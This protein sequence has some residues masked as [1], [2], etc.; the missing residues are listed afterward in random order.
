MLVA[1]VLCNA[2][3]VFFCLAASCDL[4]KSPIASECCFLFIAHFSTG[5]ISLSLQTILARVLCTLNGKGAPNNPLTIA[6]WPLKVC[7][8]FWPHVFHLLVVHRLFLYFYPKQQIRKKQHPKLLFSFSVLTVDCP[9]PV[10]W[11]DNFVLFLFAKNAAEK[12]GTSAWSFGV[13]FWKFISAIMQR[14]NIPA[15]NMSARIRLVLFFAVGRTDAKRCGFRRNRG[16]FR[17]KISAWCENQNE[18]VGECWASVAVWTQRKN[19]LEVNNEI[20]SK[21]RF[22][23]HDWS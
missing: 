17:G 7:S 15:W 4:T 16:N 9:P 19:A 5:K 12:R 23:V 6:K 8:T 10:R 1:W 14:K 18:N 22:K 20:L 2:A 13:F 21:C 11:Q 3:S